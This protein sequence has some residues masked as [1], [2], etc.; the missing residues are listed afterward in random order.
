MK[1]ICRAAPRTYL[2]LIFLLYV[3]LFHLHDHAGQDVFPVFL[4]VNNTHWLVNL[5]MHQLCKQLEQVKLEHTPGHQM[6][7]VCLPEWL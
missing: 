5:N 2:N 6:E 3:L 4:L 7:D 1:E